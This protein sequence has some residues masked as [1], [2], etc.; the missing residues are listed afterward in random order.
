MMLVCFMVPLLFGYVQAE[1][2]PDTR[3]QNYFAGASKTYT[4]G[5]PAG[6]RPLASNMTVC[7]LY[8]LQ[9]YCVTFINTFRAGKP[10]SDGR[11]R[12]HGTIAPLALLDTPFL[13]CHNEKSLSDLVFAS[14]AGCAH[15]TA[16]AACPGI[17]ATA[18]TENSCCTRSCTTLASC[19]KTLD[20]CLTQMWDE[21]KIVLDTGSTTW[22]M[23]TGHYWNMLAGNLLTCGFAW[24]DK[25]QIVMTQN[26][27]GS[28]S[29]QQPCPYA[30]NGGCACGTCYGVSASDPCDSCA[31]AKCAAQFKAGCKS[32]SATC[33][34]CLQGYKANTAGTCVDV[35]D[36]AAKTQC[37]TLKRDACSPFSTT[38]GFC[39]QKG[40]TAAPDGT[41]V[42]TTDVCDGPQQKSCVVTQK[43]ALCAI[44]DRNDTAKCIGCCS[45]DCL[46]YYTKGTA[47]LNGGLAPCVDPDATDKCSGPS[48]L[49][50]DARGLAPC[51]P[52]SAVCE[53]TTASPVTSVAVFTAPSVALVT[54]LLSLC[55]NMASMSM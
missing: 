11:S 12:D 49:S 32:G 27:Y 37:T 24:N 9:Q 7:E 45:V 47:P 3:A 6:Y 54:S 34:D 4:Q 25:N 42:S 43:H 38:C 31:Q 48:K 26:F 22:T 51:K 10:F 29:A 23:A 16:G 52:G 19:Q 35:C 14:T 18:G 44:A 39:T 55:F 17:G 8:Q 2:C 41:C 46:K 36:A 50:C 15:S 40:F 5:V 21:G 53:G 28:G 13:Q 1:I 33:G 30:C 20:G